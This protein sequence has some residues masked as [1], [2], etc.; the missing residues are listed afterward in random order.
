MEVFDLRAISSVAPK[1]DLT[2]G[3]FAMLVAV[4]AA[5]AVFVPKLDLRFALVFVA[6]S[7]LGLLAVVATLAI[8]PARIYFASFIYLVVFGFFGC[9][10]SRSSPN[11]FQL[12]RR[13]VAGS[14][15]ML[16]SVVFAWWLA[17]A[18]R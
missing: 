8:Y 14:V 15:F 18:P 10:L 4:L 17:F 1:V 11:K 7:L 16:F 6:I 2:A 9:I 13:A 5:H 3:I 12:R